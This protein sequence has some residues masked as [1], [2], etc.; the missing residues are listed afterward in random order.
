MVAPAISATLYRGVREQVTAAVRDL[1]D[2]QLAAVVPGCPLWSARD[3][4]SHQAGVARD[5]VEGRLDGAPSP[6]W[7]AVHVETR[8]DRSV[9]EILDEW[10]EYGTQLED[11]IRTSSR[12]GRLL[13]NPYVDA[14]VHCA[15]LSAVVPVGRPDREVWLASLEFCLAHPKGDEPGS[16][17]VV[18]EDVGYEIGEGDPAAEAKTESYELFRAVYGRRSADQIAAWG[19][20]GEPGAWLRELARLPQTSVDQHD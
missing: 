13:N 20:S 4:L 8:K 11:L 12:K 18:T 2:D 19:W 10:E 6:A 17:R 7:T 15:D 14:G 3:L 1:P 9:G 5:F 16:L